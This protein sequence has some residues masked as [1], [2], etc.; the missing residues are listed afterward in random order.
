MA[1]MVQIK[2]KGRVTHP[3]IGHTEAIKKTIERRPA[4]VARGMSFGAYD[5]QSA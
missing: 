4:T 2:N 3:Y 1:P 5:R